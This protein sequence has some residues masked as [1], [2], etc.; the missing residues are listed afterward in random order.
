MR[1]GVYFG[2]FW[3]GLPCGMISEEAMIVISVDRCPTE[4]VTFG[5]D[6]KIIINI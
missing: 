2:L 4:R 6:N 5:V 3:G 1:A